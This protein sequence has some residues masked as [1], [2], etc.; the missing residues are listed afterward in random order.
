M[1]EEREGDGN[2]IVRGRE[3]DGE[4]ERKKGKDSERRERKGKRQ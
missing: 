3:R 2:E 1:Y 4:R